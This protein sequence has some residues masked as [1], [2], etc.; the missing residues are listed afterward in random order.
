MIAQREK[1]NK[2]WI[3]I[4]RQHTLEETTGSTPC[5]LSE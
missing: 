3:I 5:R 4:C 1:E 2:T